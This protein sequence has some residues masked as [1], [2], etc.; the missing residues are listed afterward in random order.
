MALDPPEPQTRGAAN[1]APDPRRPAITRRLFRAAFLLY[2]AAA[3]TITGILIGEVY[4][5]T[6]N[7][8]E[9]ELSIYQRMLQGAL[10]NPLWSLEL[11]DVESIAAGMVEIPEIKGVLGTDHNQRAELLRV[12]V[13]PGEPDAAGTGRWPWIEEPI[14]A[15]FF[16]YHSHA[17][18]RDRVGHVTLYSSRLVVL[19]RARWRVALL[20]ATAIVKTIILWLIFERVSRSILVRPLTRL[21]DAARRTNIQRLETVEFDAET[22]AAA[23]DTET[24]ILRQ[25][26]NDMVV[27]LRNTRAALAETK[28]ELE[29]RVEE[30]TREVV[31][32]SS[33]TAAAMARVE[34]SRRQ[35]AAALEEAERAAHTKS[36]FLAL[37]SHELRTPLNSVLG[38]SELIRQNLAETPESLD[39]QSIE[40]YVAAIHE[41]GSHLLTLINDILDLSRIEAGRMEINPEWIDAAATTRTV[42]EILRDPATKQRLTLESRIPDDAPALRVDPRRY[43]QML[44]NLLSN[45]LKFTEPGGEVGVDA[46]IRD[47][48][49]LEISVV[50]TG[51]GMG[52]AEVSRVME[53]FSRAGAAQTRSPGGTGLGLP[54]V[55]RMMQLHGGRLAL[56]SQLGKGTRAILRFPPNCHKSAK[57]L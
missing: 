43:R 22:A 24:E 30:R 52:P 41:S 17:V 54:L 48:G 8:L 31:A 6:R 14:T 40:T 25:A 47:D 46:A 55:D 21:T 57:E 7:D 56:E 13:V 15:A 26:F 42:V 29:R 19:E 18:G 37:V 4:V 1:Q 39:P 16:V 36:E 20:I 49:W 33:E 34:Q 10:S 51:V 9:R 27:K 32:K 50:D 44:M 28:A 2:L 11:G 12:G 53:P 45:A 3:V 35:V 5:T 23:R 38:F